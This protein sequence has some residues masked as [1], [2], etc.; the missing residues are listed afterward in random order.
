M[1]VKGLGFKRLGL[2]GVRAYGFKGFRGLK[3]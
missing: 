1:W 2:V 3:V